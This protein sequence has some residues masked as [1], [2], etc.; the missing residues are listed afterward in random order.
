MLRA[1]S[2]MV[3]NVDGGIVEPQSNDFSYCYNEQETAATDVLAGICGSVSS[4]ALGSCVTS[5][6]DHQKVGGLSNRRSLTDVDEE[7]CSDDSCGEEIN[8]SVWRMKRDLVL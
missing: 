2:L 1:A 7:T 6:V 8:S 3:A 4:E 5:S